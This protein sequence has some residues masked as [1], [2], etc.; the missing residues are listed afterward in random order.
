MLTAE[1]SDD[2]IEPT[3]IQSNILAAS[4]SDRQERQNRRGVWSKIV[5]SDHKDENERFDALAPVAYFRISSR[6]CAL[7]PCAN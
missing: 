4:A 7:N 5:D 1:I 3:I 6:E 2:R